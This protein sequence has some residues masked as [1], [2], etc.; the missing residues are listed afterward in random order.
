MGSINYIDIDWPDLF[1]PIPKVKPNRFNR[2]RINREI[3]PII[4]VPGIMGSRLKNGKSGER[5]WDPDREIM[6]MLRKY[7]GFW[8]TPAQRKRMLIGGTFNAEYLQV[9]ERNP[10]H[11]KKVNTFLDPW[12]AERGWGG[13]YWGSYG[14]FLEELQNHKWDMPVNPKASEKVQELVGKCFEFP[15]YAFGYNWTDTNDNSGAKLAKRISEIKAWYKSKGRLCKYVILVSHSMGGLVCRSACVLHHAETDVLGVIHGVQPVTGAAAAYWRMKAGFER[16]GTSAMNRLAGKA[17]AWVLGTNGE[18][19]T[20][21]LGNAPGGLELLPNQHYTDNKGERGWLR[22]PLKG[23]KELALPRHGDPYKE[24]YKLKTN[25]FWRLINPDWL[26]PRDDL[27]KPF[28]SVNQ[29][30]YGWDQYIECIEKAETFHKSLNDLSHRNTY[31]FYSSSLT[32]VDKISF[33]KERLSFKKY[34][35]PSD[36]GFPAAIETAIPTRKSSTRGTSVMYVDNSDQ[37]VNAAQVNRSTS[38]ILSMSHPDDFHS[39]GDG[40]VPDSSGNA[41][42]LVLNSYQLENVGH[43]EAYGDAKAMEY[44]FKAVRNLALK[45]VKEGDVASAR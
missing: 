33:C 23:G 27:T 2:I 24:I 8:N 22:V 4:F 32:T 26:E 19:V 6:C 30:M 12:R 21:I 41:L 10:E 18:E 45:R 36:F 25:H 29:S 31:Q 34:E 13:V 15:V 39:G 35:M 14:K 40:T 28:R 20:C 37:E 38:Y 7:G 9:D 11:N 1:K 17:S 16:T 5:V 43:Q 3:I 42:K 44:V